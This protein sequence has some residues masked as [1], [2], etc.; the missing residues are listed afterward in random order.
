MKLLVSL[1]EGNL[2]TEIAEELSESIEMTFI[3]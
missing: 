1:L 2:E 3:R